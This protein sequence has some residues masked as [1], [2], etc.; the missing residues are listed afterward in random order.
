[1]STPSLSPLEAD[2]NCGK[3]FKAI[4]GKL[5]LSHETLRLDT[6]SG[7]VF[8][9]R[10]TDIQKIV[11]HWYSFSGAFE[12]W[13]GGTSYFLSFV[14]RNAGRGSWNRGMTEG[15]RFRAALEGRDATQ[16]SSW[17]LKIMNAFMMLAQVFMMLV[18]LLFYLMAAFSD[19]SSKQTRQ[20]FQFYIPGGL[21]LLLLVSY[22]ILKYKER[23]KS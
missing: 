18:S 15:R 3:Y 4:S 11:W 8:N 9:S 13:I 6:G 19:E 12:V 17:G 14:P 23:R 5:T 21:V 10:V 7:C 2:V 20:I 16:E 22:L 1:M